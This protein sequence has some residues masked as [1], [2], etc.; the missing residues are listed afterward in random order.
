[1]SIIVFFLNIAKE[2]STTLAKMRFIKSLSLSTC[3]L[4]MRTSDE[5]TS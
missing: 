2:S 5:N 4:N 1:M 3:E